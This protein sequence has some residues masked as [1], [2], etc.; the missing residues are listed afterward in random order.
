MRRFSITDKL[1]IASLLISVVTIII[2]ASYSYY[3][4]KDAILDRSF[5]QLNSVRVIKTNLI[6]KFFSDCTKEV[7]LVKSSKDINQL[8]KQINDNKL[9]DDSINICTYSEFFGELSKDYYSKI[10]II[11]KNKHLFF[12]NNSNNSNKV[13]SFYIDTLWNKTIEKED[14]YIRDYYR[15]D[16]GRYKNITISSAIKDTDGAILGIIVF[17]IRPKAIDMIMLNEDPTNGLG[18]SGETYL[19]GYDFLMRSSSRFQ[20]ESVLKTKVNTL[21]VDSVFAGMS[22]TKVIND[23]RNIVVLSSYSKINIPSLNWVLLSEIDYKEVLKPIYKIRNEIE[24]ISIFIFTIVLFVVILLSR[25]LTSPIEKLILASKEVGLGNLDVKIDNFSDDEIGEL[26]VTFNQMVDK[27]KAQA[28]DLEAEKENSIKSLFNGQEVERQRLSRELHDSLG[29]LLIGLKLKYESCVNK[30]KIKAESFTHLGLL[31]DQ[32]IEETRRISNNL[33]PAA[34]SEFGLSTAVRNICNDISEITDINVVYNTSGSSKNIDTE[35][36]I[37]LFRI[38]QEALT[39]ILKHSEAINAVI[40]IN[41]YK[42]SIFV[43]IFDNGIGFEK[44]MLKSKNSNGLNNIK[45]RISL[46]KGSCVIDSNKGKG[47][48]ISIEIPLIKANYV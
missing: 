38:I 39:N 4:A 36:K 42:E 26:S 23:Y 29:Q 30:S 45:D 3:N 48:K 43:D 18:N 1:I 2:V 6:E 24:F 32:T 12:I 20:K 10:V 33:M 14:V 46:L 28:K 37:Y 35:I 34:L 21:A 27:L 11:G 16:S 19:V 13:S 7:Q 47:T 8:V 25:K 40:N 17:E 22:G 15:I 44:Q 41:Y 31:F 5:H 9:P